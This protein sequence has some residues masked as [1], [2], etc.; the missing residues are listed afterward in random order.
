MKFKK[1]HG[2]SKSKI[3]LHIKNKPCIFGDEVMEFYNEV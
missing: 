1:M 2:Q 3:C